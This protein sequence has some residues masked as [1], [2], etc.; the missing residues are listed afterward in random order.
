MQ[1]P[2]LDDGSLGA[3]GFDELP[4]RSQIG[5]WRSVR[6]AVAATFL[7]S[8]AVAL[9]LRSTLLTSPFGVTGETNGKYTDVVGLWRAEFSVVAFPKAGENILLECRYSAGSGAD[10]EG[11]RTSRTRMT[12][13]APYP[14][15]T[16]NCATG[17]DS[18]DSVSLQDYKYLIQYADG[19]VSPEFDSPGSWR[20]WSWGQAV[21]PVTINEFFGDPVTV[22]DLE[23]NQLPT[24]HPYTDQELIPHTI[25]DESMIGT[26]HLEVDQ[27]AFDQLIEASSKKKG[28]FNEERKKPEANA[29]YTYINAMHKYHADN[30]KIKVSGFG[31]LLA[32][33]K[34]FVIH[35]S[36]ED[37]KRIGLKKHK[38]KAM[39]YDP[40]L[41][42]EYASIDIWRSMG[43]PVHRIA[44]TRLYINGKNMG[45]YNNLEQVT[46]AY[47]PQRFP[48]SKGLNNCTY[49]KCDDKA[50]FTADTVQMCS[51]EKGKESGW[52]DLRDLARVLTETSDEDFPTALEKV[53]DV[54]AFLKAAA[55]EITVLRR[56]G[57]F[58]DGSNYLMWHNPAT[59]K[60]RYISWDF[61]MNMAAPLNVPMFNKAWSFFIKPFIHTTVLPPY[62][63][64]IPLTRVLQVPEWNTQYRQ[65]AK[66]A[67]DLM[68]SSAM[69]SR[70]A[71]LHEL[72]RP[73]VKSDPYY[74]LDMGYTLD[75]FDKAFDGMVSMKLD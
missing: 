59:G 24:V 73:Y 46:A 25:Y 57:Y 38:V 60:W 62:I 45:L 9:S 18:V 14:L 51:L 67:A 35:F 49:Y 7:T 44:W 70:L 61:E 5:V 50:Y 71:Y 13:V 17:G 30:V 68:S 23:E 36:K 6:R 53:F 20:P 2:L 31:S 47:F 58:D 16:A 54:H 52:S 39:T 27:G 29:T 10:S 64:E 26:V 3:L 65:F 12:H 4:V 21:G 69:D 1:H 33:K 55:V 8:L 32:K 41:V 34:S 56:D 19:S 11:H 43:V 74:S 72:L 75:D 42:H 15:F 66:E 37:E 48:A 63:T 40:S 22:N 28:Y